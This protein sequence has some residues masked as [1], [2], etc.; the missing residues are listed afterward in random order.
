MSNGAGGVPAGPGKVAVG[1]GAERPASLW[2]K[3]ENDEN[4]G[5]KT[6]E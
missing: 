5:A 1:S 3:V 4:T 2:L 6:Y